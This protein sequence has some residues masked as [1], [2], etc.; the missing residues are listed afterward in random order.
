MRLGE[1][2]ISNLVEIAYGTGMPSS[3]LIAFFNSF[4]LNHPVVRMLESKRRFA[5][6]AW[7]ELNGRPEMQEAINQI[8]HPHYW[9]DMGERDRQIEALKRSV[10]IDGFDLVQEDRRVVLVPRSG[11]AATTVLD[12]VRAHGERLNHENVLTRIHQ[13]ERSCQASPGDAIGAAK[14]LIEA[15]AKDIIERS[16]ETYERRASPN[17]LVKQT[18]K[19]LKLAPDDIPDQARGVDAIRATLMALTNIAHQLDELRAL[20]GSGHGKPSSAKGLEPRHARL[21]VGAAGTLCLFLLEAFGE[22]RP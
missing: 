4:G 12:H 9:P 11:V 7:R 18:L 14:E 17:A 15:V 6:Q 20:Y 10:R 5:D 16:G 22:K 21:A 1:G 13:I 8:L 19:C 2:A 3:S